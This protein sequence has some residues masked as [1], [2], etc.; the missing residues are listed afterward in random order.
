MSETFDPAEHRYGKS[1]YFGDFAVGERY[2][3]PSRP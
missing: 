3:I 2:Y 1:R